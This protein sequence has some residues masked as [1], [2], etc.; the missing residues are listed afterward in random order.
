M[1]RELQ[2][3]RKKLRASERERQLI[4]CEMHDG[5]AQQLGAAIM[6]F[7]I[8]E[9]L[10]RDRHP[11]R[12]YKAYRAGVQMLQQALSE[13]RRLISGAG[14]PILGEQGI[15]AALS[16]LVCQLSAANGPSITLH[17]DTEVQ[18]LAKPL[19]HA[20]YRIAQESIANALQHSS[21]D[22][23]KLSLFREEDKLRMEVEDWGVGFDLS[24]VDENRFGLSGIRERTRLLGGECSIKSELGKGTCVR[25]VL[26][27][28]E[29][30]SEAALHTEGDSCI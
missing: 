24:S 9:H 12:A 4:Y 28:L 25:V 17:T 3:L 2:A 14:P 19:E 30:D 8:H 6:Q 23:V 11:G 18:R 20:I 29:F 15:A 1:E 5:L 27:I 22:T 10:L 16:H 26:P 13:A 21:S 7:Q